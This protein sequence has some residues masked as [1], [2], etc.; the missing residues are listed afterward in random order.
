MMIYTLKR[1]GYLVSFDDDDGEDESVYM[2]QW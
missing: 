1:E 2:C